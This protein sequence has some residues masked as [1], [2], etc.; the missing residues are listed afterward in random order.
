M[1]AQSKSKGLY[2][3][4]D[5][6]AL[7]EEWDEKTREIVTTRLE[8]TKLKLL[9]KWEQEMIMALAQHLAYENR[10]EILHWI[11]V[12]IDQ[13]LVSPLG[14]GQRSPG[15]PPQKKLVLAG[16]RAI[17]HWTK[18]RFKTKF[19]AA[20]EQQQFQIIRSLQL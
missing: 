6:L 1:P 13:Q 17:D 5:V 4:Y 2:P 8:P 19:L 18:S 16:L 11:V 3:D 20:S 7:Q 9:T 10:D 14:E 15:S 12:H